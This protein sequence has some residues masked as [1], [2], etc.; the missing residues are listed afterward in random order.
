MKPWLTELRKATLPKSLLGKAVGYFLNQWDALCLFTGNGRVAIDNNRVERQMRCV[1][2]GR[3][4]WLFA[5]SEEG[6]HRAAAIYSLV[7]T[8]SLLGIEPWAYLKDVLQKIAEGVDPATLTPRLWKA[9]R[10]QAAAN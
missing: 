10:S 4:N 2:V 3:K 1:A 9:A 5:G 6:G 8:C 7:C